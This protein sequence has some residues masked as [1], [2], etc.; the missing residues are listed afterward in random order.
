[1]TQDDAEE[2]GFAP[3]RLDPD[4]ECFPCGNDHRLE[5]AALL[6]LPLER[7]PLFH[8]AQR[9]VSRDAHVEVDK[10][11]YS[12]PPQYL[13]RTVWVRWDAGMVRV[14]DHRLQQVAV[15]ARS[16]PGR[17]RTNPEHIAPEKISG[18]ERGATYLLRKVGVI[19]AQAECWATSMLQHRGIEGVRVLVG[20]LSLGERHP[21]SVVDE[22]CAIAQTHGAYRLR[23]LRAL[24]KRSAPKQEQFEFIEEHPIIRRLSD[25]GD[26]VRR[27]FQE[28]CV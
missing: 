25:Y 18:V 3:P 6:P 4:R 22:A 23:I 10:A 28:A 26:L 2:V 8:E 13:G 19:G 5:R 17:F 1:M 21:W 12:V 24:I 11:F 16:E 27:S 15:H 7:F 14:F 20:L 9:V